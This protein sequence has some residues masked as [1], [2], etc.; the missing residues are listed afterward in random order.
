MPGT[1]H[2][3]RPFRIAGPRRRSEQI[4]GLPSLTAVLV[5]LIWQRVA[6]GDS[7]GASEDAAFYAGCW[8]VILLAYGVARFLKKTGRLA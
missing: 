3:G 8:G 5:I 2:L 7:A 1:A 4:G 6:N